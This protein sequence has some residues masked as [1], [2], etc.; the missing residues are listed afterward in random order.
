MKINSLNGISFKRLIFC[1]DMH[2]H[3]KDIDAI[4]KTADKQD[5]L[6]FM[7]EYQT[8]GD[9]F[10]VDKMI[11]SSMDCLCYKDEILNQQIFLDS[12]QLLF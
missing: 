8:E 3:D 9:V 1:T 10:V 12:S 5:V 6:K 11:P 7:K 2:V 4:G